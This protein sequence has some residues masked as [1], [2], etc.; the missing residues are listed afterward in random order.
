MTVPDFDDQPPLEDAV[1]EY[2][3]RHLVTY[4]RLLAALK[5]QADWQE[6]AHV[7]FGIDAAVEPQRA[8]DVYEPSAACPM[9]DEKGLPTLKTVRRGRRLIRAAARLSPRHGRSSDHPA[10]LE[11]PLPSAAFPISRHQIGVSG[12]WFWEQVSREWCPA[13]GN[14]PQRPA[15]SLRV[16]L[17]EANPGDPTVSDHRP[18]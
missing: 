6:A 18:S 2:D 12:T 11:A 16:R 14:L 8:R 3:K 15:I 7:L 4:L 10:F 1:T 17:W 13:R 9:D 5:E